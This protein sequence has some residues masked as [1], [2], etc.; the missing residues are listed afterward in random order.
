VRD[1]T[2]LRRKLLELSEDVSRQ[3]RQERLRG[4]AIKLK[5]RWSD[6]TTLTRQSTLKASIN[7]AIDIYQAA[8]QF[9]ERTWDGK[10]PVRLIGVGVSHFE[11][12]KRQYE[13]WD[14]AFE[15]SEPQSLK[16]ALAELRE[17]FG[18]QAVRRGTVLKD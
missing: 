1:H 8:Q 9:L 18:D 17:R 15:A 5:L 16:T 2:V 7:Q 10:R 14:G 12:A 3:L 13:L 4:S 11:G 6:F